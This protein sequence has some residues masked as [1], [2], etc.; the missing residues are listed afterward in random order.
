MT[1]SLKIAI[2]SI[3]VCSAILSQVSYADCPSSRSSHCSAP[4]YGNVQPQETRQSRF[5]EKERFVQRQRSVSTPRVETAPAI[6]AE[7]P[8]SSTASSATTAASVSGADERFLDRVIDKLKNYNGDFEFLGNVFDFVAG[9][10][11][12]MGVVAGWMISRRRIT[13][14]KA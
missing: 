8:E 14:A 5:I 9:G 10:L 7:T 1:S 12:V 3:F 2:L 13:A 4:I 6:V 11:S